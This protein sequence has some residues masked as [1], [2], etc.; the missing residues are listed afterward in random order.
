MERALEGLEPELGAVVRLRLF[1]E[2]PVRTLAQQLGLPLST[3]K[4]RLVRGVRRYREVLASLL[5][6]DSISGS[7]GST[8]GRSSRPAGGGPTS[9][10]PASGGRAA[11]E[12]ASDSSTSGGATSP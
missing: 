11:G 2:L 1:E 12:P 7:G 6:G 9:G 5:P 4:Q 3:A 10:F 8:S